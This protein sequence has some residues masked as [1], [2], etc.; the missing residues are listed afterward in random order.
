MVES[1]T[2]VSVPTRIGW[3]SV[4][5]QSCTNDNT[6]L[7][8]ICACEAPVDPLNAA[9]EPPSL[10]TETFTMDRLA[11]TNQTSYGIFGLLVFVLDLVAIISLLMRRGSVTHKLLWILLIFFFAIAGYATLLHSRS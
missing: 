4:S 6:I 5:I 8:R 1:T 9:V 11:F 7:T 2:I 3:R 10:K